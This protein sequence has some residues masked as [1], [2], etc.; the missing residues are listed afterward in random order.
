MCKAVEEW[1]QEERAEGRA[2]ELLS[3]VNDGILTASV[4]A[5]RCGKTETEFADI[6]T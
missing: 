1:R 5:A 3:L 4:A 6:E 2:E